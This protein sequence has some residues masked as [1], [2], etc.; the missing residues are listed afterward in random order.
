[1]AYKFLNSLTVINSTFSSYNSGGTANDSLKVSSSNLG[2]S[3]GVQNTNASGYAGI[4]YIDNSGN[5]KVFTGFNNGNGQE[6]RFNNVASGGYIDFLIG[7]TTGLKL[8]NNRNVTIG[9]ATDAGYKLDVNGTA[10]TKNDFLNLDNS[11]NVRFKITDNTAAGN[12][13][14]FLSRFDNTKDI[15]HVIFP[16]GTL[17]SS[18]VNWNFG[19]KGGANTFSI[20]SYNGTSVSERMLIYNNGN[21]GIGTSA[22]AG[23][24]LDVNGTTRF[25][26][27]SLV[28]LNQNAETS[29]IV[30]NTT[31]G[32]L[33]NSLVRAT[34]SS[35]FVQM[36]KYSATTTTY[37]NVAAN[38]GYIYNNAVGNISILNDVGTGNINF[39]ARGS[40][41]A[42]V[43]FNGDSQPLAL[44]GGGSSNFSMNSGNDVYFAF[45]SQSAVGRFYANPQG[46]V[47][48]T[49]DQPSSVGFVGTLAGGSVWY[50]NMNTSGGSVK[51]NASINGVSHSHIW[52]HNF[53]E[54]MRLAY[55]GNLLIGTSTDAGYKLDVNGTTRINSTLSLTNSTY[56]GTFSFY[57]SAANIFQASSS[58]VGV[59]LQV[60]GG[61]RV[62]IIGQEFNSTARGNIFGNTVGGEAISATTIIAQSSGTTATTGLS[63]RYTINN[64]GTYVGISRGIYYNPTITSLTG[65][66]H[67]AIETVTGDVIFGS[68]SGNVGIGT[69]TPTARLTVA[70]QGTGKALIGDPGFGSN[71]YT[72]ISLNGFLTTGDYNI[73]SSPTDAT[74]YINR[75]SGAQ[76][77]FREA[78]GVDQVTIATGGN[79]LIGTSTD[80]GY[81]LQVNGDARVSGSSNAT[82]YLN[83][84][85]ANTW[86]ISSAANGNFYLTQDGVVDAM[87]V[88]SSS[89][90]VTFPSIA[91][92]GTRMVV[93]DSAGT[94]ST[95][96]IPGGGS[97]NG[98]WQDNN[99]QTAAASLTGYGV[100]FST[101]NFRTGV[102]VIQDT[103]GKYTLIQM[104]NA[105]R[106]NIQFSFQFQNT[107]SSAHDVYV[108]FRK[109][110]ETTADD[111]PDSNTLISIPAKHG[112]G[113]PGHIVAAWNFF[114]EAAPMDFYQ[115]AWAT[116]D[117]TN[118]TMEYYSPTGFCPSTPSAIL[119]VNQVD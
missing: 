109:N 82:L 95:Q 19:M 2:A 86:R 67:R 26:G 12:V 27:N 7:G 116:N 94:L 44:I 47:Q 8:F 115:I 85:S 77:R 93:A 31:S 108:W 76:I 3:F 36:G 58:N 43:I 98:S 68:T 24:K 21:V 80:A 119:T 33:S 59:W 56:A 104:T 91:G 65:T 100:E 22:D 39:S 55:T 35:G 29:L 52:Y 90:I 23:Y 70:G 83:N 66:T 71:N 81:K 110:G 16:N 111:I 96:A 112:S 87:I 64:T 46:S 11:S 45:N 99:T 17:T 92:S 6:F 20:A 51:Y 57:L 69:T 61:N 4:E 13:Y 105:G 103:G 32:T 38:D 28:S 54:Q 60:G 9:S 41:A 106:Y 102:N 72:G 5:V 14:T 101:L 63:L 118:V 49:Y 62:Y 40:S 50:G 89:A 114:V 107:S 15:F 74:V 79:V 42:Q 30:S 48:Y 75:P 88:N 97:A 53:S 18:N 113:T 10:R 78:N 34:S 25:Q 73:L 84:T 37:K 1:M 117:N